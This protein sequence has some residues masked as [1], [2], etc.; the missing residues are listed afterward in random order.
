MD[1]KVD[2]REVE[3]IAIVTVAEDT[4]NAVVVE[5]GSMEDMAEAEKA[6]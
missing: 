4:D 1:L 3:D 2:G 5:Q 6:Y